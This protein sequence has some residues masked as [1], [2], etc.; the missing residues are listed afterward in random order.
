MNAPEP[1]ANPPPRIRMLGLLG[2][3]AS[4][5]FVGLVDGLLTYLRIPAPSRRISLLVWLLFHCMAALGSIGIGAGLL[6]EILMHAAARRARL[7]SF[8]SFV[9]DG[10]RKWFVRDVDASLSLAMAV[11]TLAP[12]W[13]L[14][15]PVSWLIMHSFHS[16][17]LMALGIMLA[18]PSLF[19]ICATFAVVLAWPLEWLLRKLGRFAS[20]G[21]VA[22]VSLVAGALMLTRFIRL[23]WLTFQFL[24]G[25]AAVT[26]AAL[27][28]A[29]FGALAALGLRFPRRAMAVRWRTVGIVVG[30]ALVGFLLSGLTLGRRQ[31]VLSTVLQRSLITRFIIR[32]LQSA[33]DLDRDGYG[34]LFGGGDCNDFDRRIHPGARDIPGNGID[35]N[36][37]GRD[38]RRNSDE[39]D[40]RY[41]TLPE[42]YTHN[43]TNF[44]FLSIDTMRPDHMS[45]NG[46]HRPTTPN[47][48]RFAAGAARF[49]RAYCTSPRS[50]RSF[51][52]IWTGRYPS[53]ISWG[54]D[55]QF[56]PLN[57]E[58]ITLA[59]VLR[60]NGYE[61]SAFT[62]ALY[63]SGTPGFYQGFNFYRE[64]GTFIKEDHGPMVND[65]TRWLE[66]HRGGTR[67]FFTWI[68]FMEPHE[69]YEDR[70]EPREFG[71]GAVDRYDEEIARADQGFGR[72]M[73]T[74][75]SMQ[76]AGVPIVVVLF[77]DHGEAFN[78]HGVHGHSYDL[79]EEAVRVALMV[80]GPEIEPGARHGLS[81]LFDLYPTVTNLANIPLPRPV[82]SRSLAPL[83]F[84]PQ[85]SS[86]RA[87][88]RTELFLEVTPDGVMPAEVKAF[89]DPP[90]TAIH[91]LQRNS[92]EL[93]DL[94]RDPGQQRNI[95]DDEPDVAQR[96]RARLLD[97]IESSGS[98]ANRT[99]DVIDA[100][101]LAAPPR[102]MRP[103]GIRFGSAFDLLGTLGPAP[104]YRT[105]ES[106]EFSAILRVRARTTDPSWLTVYFAHPGGGPQPWFITHYPILGRYL[107]TQ[108]NPGEILRD[109]MSL[110]ITPQMEP[111]MY[112][113][114]FSAELVQG[115]QRMTPSARGDGWGMVEI[116]TFEIVR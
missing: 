18:A 115:G 20:P 11:V 96:M 29:D 113:I 31:A 53:S 33:V 40:G 5:A 27:L 74:I 43:R 3:I 67:P 23:H 108:W 72:V 91:D 37:S 100:H 61:T 106:I 112:R 69:P 56:P 22:A 24:D 2:A 59:E 68:H 34:T 85:R 49:D 104:R 13:G 70:S 78:E 76:A 36:C 63:F 93:Y 77:S 80:R 60:D 14:L 105:G 7:R 116:G 57:D 107:T 66:Q 15:F 99:A 51:A 4:F 16:R 42:T 30:V 35:E 83:L 52:S 95:Y 17:I 89:I 84:G 90:W 28:A 21:T 19:A 58:N 41:G 10:P 110:R 97:W 111:G 50:L 102:E 65:A 86:P 73:A 71:H 87:S 81:S 55:N 32:P 62:N 44:V 103:I 6:Q 39:G 98:D 12:A 47:I 92:W 46:Y 45:L 82:P 75:D 79:H 48:D 25:R 88:W 38:A 101:R 94:R 109:P 64:G 114:L 9:L 26:A 54:E 8:A 1:T